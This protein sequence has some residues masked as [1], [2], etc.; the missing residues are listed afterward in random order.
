MM[1]AV[2]Y[3]NALGELGQV[4][5]VDTSILVLSDGRRMHFSDAL[6]AAASLVGAPLLLSGGGSAPIT[7]IEDVTPP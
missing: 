5:G 2:T 7:G 6:A 3:R 1:I 4:A